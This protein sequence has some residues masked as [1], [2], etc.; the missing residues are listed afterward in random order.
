MVKQNINQELEQYLSVFGNFWQDKCAELIPFM[1]FAHNARQHCA[2]GKS[3]FEVW[4]RFQPVFLPPV[5]FATKIPAEEDHL[6]TLDQI[7]TEVTAVLKVAA[8]VMKHLRASH[9][10][11][12]IKP[13]DLVWSEGINVHTTHPRAKLAPRQHGL[14]KIIS[15]WGVNCNL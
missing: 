2:T 14:F 10:T 11:Y 1:E 13:G 4:Y 3:P 9:A 7:H 6:C 12:Q 5:N 15:T 8:E